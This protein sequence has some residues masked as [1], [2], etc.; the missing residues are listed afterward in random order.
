VDE[1]AKRIGENEALFRD[2]NE[3]LR[4][5]GEGFSLVTEEGEFVCECGNAS[6]VERIRM[7]LSAYEETRS[8]PKHFIVAKGH[9]ALEYEKVLSEGHGYVIVE[10]LPG[11]PAGA[12]IRD[13]PRS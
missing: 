13:D 9:E 7:P 6:C 3:R 11:G 8:D 4:E 12:A 1:R 5:V 2:V 10:K